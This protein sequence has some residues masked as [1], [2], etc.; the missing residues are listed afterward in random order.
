[1][2]ACRESLVCPLVLGA[3]LNGRFYEN[4]DYNSLTASETAELR[5]SFDRGH[6]GIGAVS[7]QTF[8][9]QHHDVAA[10]SIGPRVSA[11]Y[12]PTP[13]SSIQSTS[14]LEFNTYP[15]SEIYDGY[16][17]GETLN[18]TYAFN[19]ATVGFGSVGYEFTNTD[20]DRLDSD[21]FSFGLGFYREL[22][23]GV[24]MT[25]DAKLR[26]TDYLGTW[27]IIGDERRDRRYSGSLSLTKRDWSV[28]GYAPEVE[29]SY[30]RNDSNIDIY[31]TQGHSVDLRLTKDF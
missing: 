1:M 2:E 20:F 12:R 18:G 31:E 7:S 22:P 11:L 15:D 27:S 25:A 24:S 9:G 28:W 26:L 30:S 23:F 3:G 10:Y 17:A 8:S 19:Q 29:Y 21:A 13:K 14:T 6:V 4:S 16:S 5:H